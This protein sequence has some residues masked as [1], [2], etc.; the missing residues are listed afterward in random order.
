M[1]YNRLPPQIALFLPLSGVKS[2]T[3]AKSVDFNH[4]SN[5]SFG[6]VNYFLRD[7]ISK[8]G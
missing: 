8:P 6:T 3:V 2:K 1:S 4:A 5:R 7:M